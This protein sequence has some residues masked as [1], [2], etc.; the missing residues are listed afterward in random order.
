GAGAVRRDKFGEGAFYIAQKASTLVSDFA[1]RSYD[2]DSPLV[3]LRN[4]ALAGSSWLRVHVTSGD[5]NM[6]PLATRLKLATTSMVLRLIEDGYLGE[7]LM[8]KTP[9]FR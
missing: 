7:D 4:E 2:V 9:M 6:S 8:P 3:G 5:A 1:V